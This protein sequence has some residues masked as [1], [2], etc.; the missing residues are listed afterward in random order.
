MPRAP[1]AKTYSRKSSYKKNSTDAFN[2]LLAKNLKQRQIFN[3]KILQIPELPAI[4]ENHHLLA[5]S[6]EN[7]TAINDTFDKLLKTSQSD[8]VLNKNELSKADLCNTASQNCKNV[9]TEKQESTLDK[10]VI[11]SL[12]IEKDSLNQ[13]TDE[14]FNMLKNYVDDS[15]QQVHVNGE[16]QS[17]ERSF[18]PIFSKNFQEANKKII[19]STPAVVVNTHLEY[20]SSINELSPISPKSEKEEPYE[21]RHTWN[22]KINYKSR[23][24]FKKHRK[25]KIVNKK[26][27]KTF[28]RIAKNYI[29]NDDKLNMDP[30]VLVNNSVDI[31]GISSS[32]QLGF[33]TKQDLSNVKED[34]IA[35]PK[36]PLRYNL[37]KR[38]VPITASKST[39]FKKNEIFDSTN[40]SKSKSHNSSNDTTDK[41]I[42]IAAQSPKELQG[43][44]GSSSCESFQLSSNCNRLS[45][46]VKVYNPM[47]VSASTNSDDNEISRDSDEELLRDEIGPMALFSEDE[48]FEINL[49]EEYSKLNITDLNMSYEET[50][51]SKKSAIDTE[52]CNATR[53]DSETSILTERSEINVTQPSMSSLDDDI[54]ASHVVNNSSRNVEE[55][56]IVSTT[57]SSNET[58]DFINGSNEESV[59]FEYIPS[60]QNHPYA[61]EEHSYS[62]TKLESFTNSSE[63]LN[64]LIINVDTIDISSD[65]E[66]ENMNYSENSLHHSIDAAENSLCNKSNVFNISTKKFEE[67]PLENK[68]NQNTATETV[69][70][71]PKPLFLKTGKP[72]RR[73]LL[74]MRRNSLLNSSTFSSCYSSANCV[75]CKTN[76]PSNQGKLGRNIFVKSALSTIRQSINTSL[77]ELSLAVDKTYGPNNIKDTLFQETIGE[78]FHDIPRSNSIYEEESPHERARS[79]VL[80]K[81]GQENPIPFKECYSE[82]TLR[83]CRKIGEGVYGEVFLYKNSEGTGTVMK[84]IPIEGDQLVNDEPQKKYSEIVSEIIIAMELSNLRLNIKNNTN[85]FSELRN[86]KCVQGRYPE[87]LLDLWDLYNET[88]KSNNDSPEMFGENQLYIVLEL[89]N[90]GLDMESF[91]FK[92]ASEAYALFKQISFTLAIAEQALE[93]EH[94]DLHWGNVLISR[95]DKNKTLKYCLD[96]RE[97]FVLSNGVEVSIIDFTLSRMK[98][99][100]AIIYNDISKDPDLFTA[101]GEYQFEVYKLMQ[102]KNNNEWEHFEAYTN[103]LWMHYVVDKM[104]NALRYASPFTKTHKDALRQLMQLEKVILKY[105]SVYDLVNNEF[106]S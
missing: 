41:Q 5:D 33:S 47:N 96:G 87:R 2:A 12:C 92:N 100:D 9:S 19:S 103:V 65:E 50:P 3:Q 99:D 89:G 75:D 18:E 11:H 78:S 4:D 62:M 105:N 16:N 59:F 56:D 72:W 23:H 88:H 73:S 25:N 21:E 83:N 101:T 82:T 14:D 60:K 51:I 61:D 1:V 22:F 91:V 30:K 31:I 26:Q 27:L 20:T 38:T 29:A 49:K 46:R 17:I 24:R 28:G 68:A 104:I 36:G 67:S 43:N 77:L 76:K 35:S 80:R 79:I 7:F 95:T 6:F 8:L 53:K 102:Q 70:T 71:V 66:V 57:Q 69:L 40:N 39:K 85:G 98:I 84:V 55:S 13:K 63:S 106:L 10:S 86:V 44:Q 42:L 48:H 45:N 97:F 64:N 93:F 94:R 74:Q 81:C 37:R 15:N 32:I 58:N 52:V 34:T 54:E 90:G